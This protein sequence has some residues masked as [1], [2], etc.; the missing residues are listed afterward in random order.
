MKGF[1]MRAGE[2]RGGENIDPGLGGPVGRGLRGEH[3]IVR[4]RDLH[5][6]LRENQQD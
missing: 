1:E 4:G 3:E 6:C 5:G 2:E